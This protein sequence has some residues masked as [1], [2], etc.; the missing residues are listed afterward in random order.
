MNRQLPLLAAALVAGLLASGCTKGKKLEAAKAEAKRADVEFPH[1]IHVDQGIACEDCHA[2][3]EKATSLRQR[4]LPPKEKC[5]ECHDGYS[6]PSPDSIPEARL[7]FSHAA[8]LPQITA[9][10]KCATCHAK[11]PEM[12][13]PRF[14]PSMDTCTSCH[15][16]Q[17]DYNQGRCRPCHVTMKGL[18]PG[19]YFTHAG[20]WTRLHGPAARPSAESCAQCHDQTYCA[21]CHAATTTAARPSI[22]FPERVERDYIHR[23]D[24]VSRHM[25]DAEASPASC[26]RCHGKNFCEACH[27]QQNLRGVLLSGGRDPHPD[28]W[29]NLASGE[30]HGDAA[31][32]NAASCAACHD[33]PG[34]QNACVACHRDLAG[35]Q[36]NIHPRSFRSKR[37]EKDIADNG[38]CRACHVSG[39]VQR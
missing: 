33:Q 27:E 3:I 7:S 20:D 29:M 24:Y 38:M 32:R 19:K 37:D 15:K 6:G 25:I 1:S 9:K 5:A 36:A 14:V 26:L 28:G 34:N 13:E 31:R 18:E 17:L 10:D 16:H 8:H 35:P 23:G 2:G 30:F 21:E 22:I 11:L 4:H 12:G 39:G